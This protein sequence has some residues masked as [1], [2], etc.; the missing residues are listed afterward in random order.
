MAAT[1][2]DIRTKVRKLTRMP[3]INQLTDAVLDDYINTFIL[4]DFPE[5]L[6]LFRLHQQ[7]SAT[8]SPYVDTYDASVLTTAAGETLG[9][10]YI[11]INPPVYVDGYKAFFSQSREEFYNLY[12][13]VKNI[14][15]MGTG[16]GATTNFTYTVNNGFLLPNQ[17]AVTSITAANDGVAVNDDGAGVFVGDGVGTVNYVTG[18]IDVTFT[19]APG[20]GVDVNAHIVQYTPNRPVAVLFFNNILTVRPVPDQSYR[21]NFEVYTQP[22]ELIAAGSE[23]ELKQ[24]WQY[25]AYGAA[26]KVLEDRMDMETVQMIMPE[27]KRQEMLVQRRTIVQQSTQRVTTIFAQQAGLNGGYDEYNNGF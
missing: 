9:N 21:L 6:R 27:F 13:Q 24:W 12:P 16:D 11:T 1:L 23:P 4:Y 10:A 2:A 14:V 20:D 19:T 8:L 22:T 15:D 25:I 3:S 7:V 18:A 26:K 17:V 5:E